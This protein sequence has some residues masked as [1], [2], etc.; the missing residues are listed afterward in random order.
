M[1]RL[2]QFCTVKIKL[3]VNLENRETASMGQSKGKVKMNTLKEA[4]APLKLKQVLLLKVVMCQTVDWL[5]CQQ[6]TLHKVTAFSQDKVRHR[7]PF[8]TA[9]SQCYSWVFIW[10]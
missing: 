7:N 2:I 6:Q 10:I 8:K 5:I 9:N 4:A 3:R 1:K